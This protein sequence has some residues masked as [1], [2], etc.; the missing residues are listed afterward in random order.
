[1][2]EMD[3]SEQVVEKHGEFELR[4]G[5]NSSMTLMNVLGALEQQE[6][7][8]YG[9]GQL[10]AQMIKAGVPVDKLQNFL[11]CHYKLLGY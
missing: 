1:M 8:G 7:D 10:L 3:F 6:I 5:Y 2:Q 11:A 4:Y 9:V